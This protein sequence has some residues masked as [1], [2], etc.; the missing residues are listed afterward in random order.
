MA[1]ETETELDR[2]ALSIFS[3]TV[4]GMP[5]SRTGEMFAIRAYQHAESFLAVQKRVKSGGLKTKSEAQSALA[6]CFAPNLP[7]THPLNLVS[8]KFGD[9]ATIKKIHAWLEAHPVPEKE[10]AQFVREFK[11]AFPNLQWEGPTLGETLA[12]FNVAREVFPAY[13]GKTV[14]V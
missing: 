5:A 9:L 6:N 10:P 3:A 7:E 8:Q 14:S 13:V 1:A 4:S 11:K 12:N 2:I